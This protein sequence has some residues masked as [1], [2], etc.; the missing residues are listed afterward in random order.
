MTEQTQA[1]DIVKIAGICQ[2]SLTYIIS[3]K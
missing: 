2:R 1:R 3:F